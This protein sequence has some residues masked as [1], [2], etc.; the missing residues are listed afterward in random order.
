MACRSVLLGRVSVDDFTRVLEA[1]SSICGVL[2][3]PVVIFVII[4]LF[5][6]HLVRLLGRIEKGRLFGTEWGFTPLVQEDRQA[7]ASGENKADQ[8]TWN[9]PYDVFW[10]VFDIMTAAYSLNLE[11]PQE[12]M[13]DSIRKALSHMLELGLD[14]THVGRRLHHILKQAENST[15]ESWGQK[16]RE[17]M[18]HELNAVFGELQQLIEQTQ[19]S[20]LP[21][22]APAAEIGSQIEALFSPKIPQEKLPSGGETVITT[23][24]VLD[25]FKTVPD[26]KEREQEIRDLLDHLHLNLRFNNVVTKTQLH[27]LVT[28]NDVLKT[29]K[30]LYVEELGRPIE[31]PLDPAALASWGAFLYIRGVSDVT[32]E[33]VRQAL[34]RS[35]EYGRK[36]R[37][38]S[39]IQ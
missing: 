13:T 36:K 26:F 39:Q 19:G 1:I 27:G 25:A 3:W 5:R 24:D 20:T 7:P 35:D 8:T 6:V 16:K 22:Y 2:A 29:L 14:N 32:V 34:R 31:R 38:N 15:K 33:A 17:F 9:K 11:D 18:H 28:S 23:Q 4:M 10:L 37:Q 30:T 21:R 12:Q